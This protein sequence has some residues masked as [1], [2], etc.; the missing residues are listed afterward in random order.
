LALALGALA[1]PIIMLY[2]LRLRRTEMQISS[3]FLWQQLVRDREANAPWQKL[4]F[5]WLL[6]L[7]LLIL[8]ALVLALARPFAKVKTITT[9]R[10]VLLLDASASMQ[11]TD[12]EPH[13]FAAAREV[14]LDLVGT[15]GADDT[16]TVIRVAEVPEVLA[17][18]SRD[19]HVL[20]NAIR[21]AEA[22]D[23]SG[24]WTAAMTLAAAGAVGVDE[25][26][27]VIIT[28]GGLPAN[29]PPVPGDVRFMSVGEDTNNLAISALATAVL[30]G[31][32]PQLFARISNYGADEAEV[33]MDLRLDG[34][35]TLYTA[36]R[37]TIPA[38]G[39]VDIFD[40]DLP[41]DFESVTA[42]LTLPTNAPS[43][44]YLTIDNRAYTIRD[45]SGA[46]RVLLISADNLFLEQIFRSLR[47][48]Q[49]S[50]TENSVNLP[51]DYDLYVFDGVLPDELPDGDVM[52]VNP[53]TGTDFFT[54]G[55]KLRPTSLLTVHPDDPRARN[56]SVFMETVNLAEFYAVSNVDWGT[57][58]VE[59]D[60]YPLVLVGEVGDRQIALLPF[61]ARYPNTDMVLQPAWP[62]LIAELTGWFSPPR[63]TDVSGVLPPG[64]PVVVRF[65]ENADQAVITR[66]DDR[67]VTLN[68]DVTE[69]VFADTL[70]PGLYRVDLQRD[71]DTFKTERFAVNLFDPLESDIE[72]GSSVVIG[73]TTISR[74]ARQE[75]GRREFWTWVV[76][77]GLVL[78]IIEW[79]VYHRS[80][81]RIPRV[82]LA[83]LWGN[84]GSQSRWWRSIFKRARGGRPKAKR[85]R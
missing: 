32:P 64:A 67:Q 34:A 27:V 48:V 41:E 72:P 38:R 40:I 82:T 26:K 78:L 61:D 2:M 22:S 62:I 1:I 80:L 54:L 9:G 8:A 60:G 55:E 6:L 75:S 24:D 15:L 39:Y 68:A 53:P 25:L 30:P 31:Q 18:A 79:L 50:R 83:G 70:R 46:G 71:G 5:S 29:L 35:D 47:G 44:D 65:I 45:R 59:V 37:Y 19:K 84:G 63:I 20:R 17:A 77:I 52:F 21:E 14:A 28:D 76:G 7:Q 74:D 3:T 43:P 23:A 11:A 69:V 81:R 13:R 85:A 57:A 66:P 33:I 36:R 10:I 4:R 49:L 58:L 56:L 73:T 16:M 42:Q 12:V 51:D